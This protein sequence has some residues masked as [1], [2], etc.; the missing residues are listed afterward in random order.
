VI[1]NNLLNN[2]Y[3]DYSEEDTPNLKI[4]SFKNVNSVTERDIPA[5]NSPQTPYDPSTQTPPPVGG[6]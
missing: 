1:A 2:K 4:D 5:S 6:R 3:N